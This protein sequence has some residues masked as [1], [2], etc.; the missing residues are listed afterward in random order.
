MTSPG[1]RSTRLLRYGVALGAAGFSVAIRL[2]F[3]SVLDQD[4]PLIVSPFAVVLSSYF[5]GLGPGIVTTVFC[6]LGSAYFI[7]EP[8]GIQVAGMRGRLDLLVFLLVGIVISVLS[9][10]VRRS[11]RRARDVSA[12]MERSNRRIATILSGITDCY[13]E[14]DAALTMIAINERAAA[15][16]GMERSSMIGRSLRDL[17]PRSGEIVDLFQES[18]RSQNPIHV[19]RPST[20]REGHW[21]E[22]HAYPTPDAVGVYFRDITERKKA[23]A[24]IERGAWLNE[25]IA[26]L[27]RALVATRSK[28]EISRLVLESARDLTH[29]SE[30][31]VGYMETEGGE[32][33]SPG[34]GHQALAVC[35]SCRRRE[36]CRM[37]DHFREQWTQ[38]LK[39]RRVL[40]SNDPPPDPED[41][42]CIRITAPVFRHLTAPAMINETLVG[43]VSVANS[44]SPYS[45]QDLQII[46][47]LASLYAIAIQRTRAE[48]RVR[49]SQERYRSLYQSIAGGVIVQNRDGLIIEANQDAASLIGLPVDQICGKGPLD[50]MWHSIHEDGMPFAPEERPGMVALRSGVGVRGVVMGIFRPGEETP[51]WMIV[52]S[53]PVLDPASGRASTVVSTFI[54][55]TVRKQALEDLKAERDFTSAV[56]DTAGSLIVVLDREGKIVR[57]NRACEEAFGYSYREMAGRTPW[58]ILIPSEE[59]DEFISNLEALMWQGGPIRS[60]NHWIAR[61]GSRRLVAWSETTISEHGETKYVIGIGIDVTERRRAEK[62]ALQARKE[63]EAANAAKDRF[64]AVLSHELRT[65]LTPVLLASGLLE[66]DPRLPPDLVDSVEL[67]RR[68]VEIEATLINDLLDLTRITRGKIE[69]DLRRL[70][71]RTVIRETVQLCADDLKKK[72]LILVTDIG[73]AN[74]PIRGEASRLKQVFWNLMK[75]ALKFTPEGGRISIRAGNIWNGSRAP[76]DPSAGL[77]GARRSKDGVAGV[78]VEITDSGIGIEPDVL[79]KIFDP[80]EQGD[81][82]VTRRFGGLG[83]GLSIAKMMTE[84]HG[85]TIVAHSPGR[86]RGSTFQITLPA[87]ASSVVEPTGMSARI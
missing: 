39:E 41:A 64:L 69:L 22:I 55:I 81:R 13:F 45:D 70:D 73:D 54:D 15:Y 30:G 26:N 51:R 11:H 61:D 23:E 7:M 86:N 12:A 43:Q 21:A 17:F 2:L 42:E 5:G 9:E 58:D 10:A 32:F 71:I 50:P 75:N 20:V 60:E 29:S 3:K 83:L 79:P 38:V 48:D 14:A 47:R 36:A 35:V 52:N 49:A 80:F 53:E 85:G 66:K 59:R 6:L 18:L 62:E 24:S 33:I 28:D 4:L 56:L 57:F 25:V 19:E 84:V 46:E 87:D 37:A 68:N 16:F 8:A 44:E 27:S 34:H 82:E 67:I 63:A 74:C 76:D 65:P 31:F 40:V 77:F 72:N 78:F 1:K